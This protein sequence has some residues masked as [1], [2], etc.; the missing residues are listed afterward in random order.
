M[1]PV[2]ALLTFSIGIAV[3]QT[4]LYAA[5]LFSPVAIFFLFHVLL[6]VGVVHQLAVREKNRSQ[7]IGK[8]V[9]AE[10]VWLGPSL[11]VLCIT[12][13]YMMSLSRA[14]SLTNSSPLA[15]AMIGATSLAYGL[16]GLGLLRWVRNPG[17]EELGM[18]ERESW[19]K[20]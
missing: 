10:V 20:A 4:V 19:R 9:L 8:G 16:I 13:G 14:E 2:V 6:L 12:L 3:S 18:W 15:L 11:I 7:V 1:K 5:V 17:N